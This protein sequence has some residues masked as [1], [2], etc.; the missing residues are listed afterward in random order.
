MLE[1]A[2]QRNKEE[3]NLWMFRLQVVLIGHK[4]TLNSSAVWSKIRPA[5]HHDGI[6]SHDFAWLSH[7]VNKSKQVNTFKNLITTF[8]VQGKK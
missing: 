5:L 6:N 7:V 2:F 1:I 4:C 3:C 8:K